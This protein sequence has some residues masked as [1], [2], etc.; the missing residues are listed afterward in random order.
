MSDPVRLLEGGD[1]L[2]VR[3]LA[4]AQDDAAPTHVRA[5][6]HAALGLAVV[7]AAGATSSTAS[8]LGAGGLGVSPNVTAA[9]TAG[10][11]QSALATGLLASAG[12]TK[13]AAA[14]LVF[15]LAAAGATYVVTAGSGASP[16][17]MASHPHGQACGP[18]KVTPVGVSVTNPA[19]PVSASPILP[20]EDET[21][22]A[23][24]AAPAA[25]PSLPSLPSRP[26][27]QAAA[28]VPS[29][30]KANVSPAPP[31]LQGLVQELIPIDAARAAFD[32]GDTAGALRQLDR[33]DLDFPHGQLAPEAL[34]LRIEVYALRHDRTKVADLASTFLARYPGHPQTARVRAI[35]QSVSP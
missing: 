22:A 16:S 4:S 35:V 10:T 34:A 19:P 14:V 27:R 3:V 12:A 1:A 25:L 5:R 13:L 20:Q 24:A 2:E 28:E 7:G 11:G 6:V 32:A 9:G 17:R 26:A 18:E 8:A 21:P 33:H 31:P 15:G 30:P 29:T 23:T